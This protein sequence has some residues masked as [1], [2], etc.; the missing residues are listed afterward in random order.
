MNLDSF[1]NEEDAG[2][3]ELATYLQQLA[4]DLHTL[5]SK[6]DGLNSALEKAAHK[7]PS[8]HPM[9]DA[10]DDM[11]DE[12]DEVQDHLHD[13]NGGMAKL[14]GLVGGFAMGWRSGGIKK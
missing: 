6:M 8:D 5:N 13:A 3:K 10:I 9:W 7:T 11:R 14:L 4:S 12:A 2:A 1:L